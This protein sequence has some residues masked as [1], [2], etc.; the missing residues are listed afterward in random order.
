MDPQVTRR[1]RTV[2]WSVILAIAGPVLGW[3]ATR[4]QAYFDDTS[5]LKT[6]VTVIETQQ[7]NIDR[8]FDEIREQ[9]QHFDAKLDR[10]LEQRR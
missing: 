3:A 10:V 9:M 4:V 2:K 6:K 7:Q 8:R 5:A 1:R